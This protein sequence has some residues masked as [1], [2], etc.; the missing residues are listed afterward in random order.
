MLGL[1]DLEVV[2]LG[3]PRRVAPPILV[4]VAPTVAGGAGTVRLRRALPAPL[5]VA[6]QALAAALLDVVELRQLME[7][8]STHHIIKRFLSFRVTINYNQQRISLR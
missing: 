2:Q 1:S 8:A 5:V 3:V 7:P 4:A 6:R